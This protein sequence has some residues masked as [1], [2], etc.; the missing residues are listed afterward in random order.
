MPT[1][2]SCASC[3]SL[4]LLIGSWSSASCCWPLEQQQKEEIISSSSTWVPTSKV[5]YLSI[6]IYNCFFPASYPSCL[7]PNC[8]YMLASYTDRFC[9]LFRNNKTKQNKTIHE[10]AI[11]M[12]QSRSI[13]LALRSVTYSSS[14]SPP[15]SY[16]WLTYLL[17]LLCTHVLFFSF[18]CNKVLAS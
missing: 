12:R 10:Q 11:T 6:Y 7:L 2:F 9:F 13:N 1:S 15:P 17:T 3:S 5:L 16:Y 14:P 8:I 4:A 18:Q